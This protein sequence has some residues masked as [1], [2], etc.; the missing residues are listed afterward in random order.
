[1]TVRPAPIM[2]PQDIRLGSPSPMKESALSSRIAVATVSDTTTR[3]GEIAFG[4]MWPSTMRAVLS[5]WHKAASTNSRPRSRRNS[6][7]VSRAS[8]GQL[9]APMVR[10]MVSSDGLKVATS[11]IARMK[12]GTVWNISVTRISTR[13]TLPPK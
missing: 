5:P 8:G 7:R 2:K 3:I 4:R 6:A 1:M 10:M 12:A 9:T 13:S 11:R